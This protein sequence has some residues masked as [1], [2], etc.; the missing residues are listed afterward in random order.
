MPTQAMPSLW[1]MVR[2][3]MRVVWRVT[4]IVFH[5]TTGVFFALFAVYGGIA[6]WRQWRY[7]PTHW[8]IAFA[9]VY[10]LMM[11]AFAYFSFRRAKRVR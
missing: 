4:R 11:A 1:D 7:R 9:V 10:A 3:T 2:I 5:E 6:A 8:V